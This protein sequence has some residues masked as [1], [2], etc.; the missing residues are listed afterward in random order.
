MVATEMVVRL[1]TFI[2]AA[3]ERVW[4]FLGTE[5]GLKAWLGPKEYEPRLNGRVLF[6]VPEGEDTYHMTGEVKRFDPPRELAFTWREQ[7]VGGE[8]W[9]VPTLVSIRL[10]PA[11]GGTVVQLTH[12]G[13]ERLPEAIAAREYAGYVRGWERRPAMTRL[14]ELVAQ[15]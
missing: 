1:Q 2:A 13:F 7:K 14:Q 9:P 15:S 11:D 10:L 4:H 6:V 5:E 8:P 12:S 3:P